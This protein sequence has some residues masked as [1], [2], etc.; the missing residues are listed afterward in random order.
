MRKNR[1]SLFI[2][3]ALGLIGFVFIFWGVGTMRSDRMQIAAR[4]NDEIITRKDFERA[5]ENLTKFYQ[6]VSPESSPPADMLQAQAIEQLISTEL[7]LQE[8]DRLGLEVD[9]SELRDWIA[10]RPEFEVDG[11]FNKDAYIEVLRQNGL[12]PSDYEELQRRSLLVNKLQTVLRQGVQVSPQEAKDRFR[13]DNERL[14]LSFVRVPASKFVDQVTL[15]DADL[16]TYYAENME[17]YREPE[18]VR[19]QVLEFRPQDFA[20]RV[21]PSDADVQTYYDAHLEEYTK[22]EEVR[23]RHIMIRVAPTAG[24]AE[25]AAARQQIEG[26]LAQAKGGADFSTLAKEHSQDP[27]AENGGDL[28]RFGRGALDPTFEAAAFALEPGQISDVVE[29]ESGLHIIKLEEKTAAHQEPLEAVKPA[30]IE[31]LKTQQAR[32]LALHRVEA[33]HERLLDGETL[34]KV[35]ADEGLTVQTPPP[36]AEQ[37]PIAGMGDRPEVVKQA[38]DTEPGQVSEIASDANGYAIVSVVERLPSGLPTLEQ[39]RG[40]VETDLRTKKAAELAK[41]RAAEMLAEVK[42]KTTLDAVAEQ[43]GLKVERSENVGRLGN[44]LPGLGMAPAL[45]DAAFAL[46]PEAP[47]APQVYDVN[48]DAVIAVLADRTPPDDSRFEGE[49][50]AVENRLRSQAEA[51]VIQKFLEQLRADARIEYGQALAAAQGG[52][53]S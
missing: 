39:V 22:P 49:K 52:T 28:G 11:R 21:T 33:A 43:Q 20:A 12:K 38:F 6:Q 10:A 9:E 8:A 30:I 46:T 15:S 29:T 5:Y 41:Q 26:L 47:V 35:A 25:K 3:G 27:S 42:E 45:K 18:R 34:E 13:F 16:Q 51:A 36:F 40:N 17:Q 48:G 1:G 53:P 44:Y 7:F 14:N 2:K 50:A 24:E 23:A 37:E 31:M 4:V 19:V 32:Q